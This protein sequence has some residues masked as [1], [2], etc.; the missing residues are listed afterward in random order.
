MSF[1]HDAAFDVLSSVAE[2]IPK[3]PEPSLLFRQGIAVGGLLASDANVRQQLF[4][5]PVGL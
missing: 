2:L 1:F 5:A 3:P 4:G